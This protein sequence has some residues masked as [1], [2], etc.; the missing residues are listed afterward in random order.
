MI[1]WSK[2]DF[3]S[4]T[5]TAFELHK[6]EGVADSESVLSSLEYSSKRCSSNV[7]A[8]TGMSLVHLRES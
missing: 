8:R 6:L 3:G 5:V 7:S 1:A 2:M 4:L